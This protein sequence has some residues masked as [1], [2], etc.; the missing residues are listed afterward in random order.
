MTPIP[1]PPVQPPDKSPPVDAPVSPAKTH[2]VLS[3]SAVVWAARAVWLAVAVVGGSAIGQALTDHSRS[4]QITGTVVAWVGW[5]AAA[6]ALIVPSTIGM[7]VVRTVVPAG[8][9]IA[10]LAAFRGAGAAEA[11]VCLGLTM[12]M[13]ALIGAAE[14]GQLFAQGSAYG[15]ER[16]FVL[17]APVAFLLPAAVSWC[18]LCAAAIA[19]PLTLAAHAWWVGVPVTVLAMVAGWF[20]GRRFHLLSRRW[21]VLVPA[22]LVVHDQ[23]VL[24]ETVMLPRSTIARVG[25]ALADTQA[26]DLTGPAAGHAVEIAL[27]EPSTVVLARSRAKPDGTA[28]H[29]RSVLVAPTRPGRLLSVAAADRLPVG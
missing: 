3:G 28:L 22:G 1:C 19:G 29:V 12:L 14:F 9:V 20:L 16:R 27:R 23:L 6:V 7:T 8:V 13:C 2:A 25:L 26:A 5:A 10:I 21:L 4:V 17:R 24:S 18:V 15:H 11:A